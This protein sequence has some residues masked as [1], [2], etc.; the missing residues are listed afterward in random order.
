MTVTSYQLPAASRQPLTAIW[1]YTRPEILQICRLLSEIALII[2]LIYRFN[3]WAQLWSPL[4]L[5]TWLLIIMLIPSNLSRVLALYDVRRHRQPFIM[6]GA[7]LLL[8]LLSLRLILYQQFSLLDFSW[9]NEFG[10][11]LIATQHPATDRDFGVLLF[12]ALV[13]WRGVSLIGRRTDIQD[14][15]LRFRIMTMAVAPAVIFL[16]TQQI[17]PDITPFI[18]LYL[19]TSLLTI[20][21]T[22]A[23]QVEIGATDAS[24]PITFNWLSRIT[25]ASGAVVLAAGLTTALLTG[26]SLGTSLGFL[27][28]LWLALQAMFRVASTVFIYLLGPLFFLANWLMTIVFTF[29]QGL[30]DIPTPPPAAT[31]DAPADN[32]PPLFDVPVQSNPLTEAIF[33]WLGANQQII[34]AVIVFTFLAI[35]I[36]IAYRVQVQVLANRLVGNVTRPGNTHTPRDPNQPRPSLRDRLANWQRQRTAATIRRIYQDM[37]WAAAKNHYPRD[38]A[39]TPHEYT[40]TLNQ[41]WPDNPNQIEKITQA[42]IQVRYGEIPETRQEFNDIK[43]AWETLK[44]TTPVPRPEKEE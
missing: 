19:L 5:T 1:H 3:P 37:S 4:L 12:S 20:A 39:Q 8:S 22:R 28:P 13:W 35:M 29:L 43:Q 14:I 26:D 15:S 9:L 36:L 44:K 41:A 30:F 6:L 33:G 32:P 42:Y 40:H 7:G 16:T 25:L 10:S 23:E 38:T 24:F 31:P 11:H 2:P 21:I 34:I 18:L 27:A 17:I